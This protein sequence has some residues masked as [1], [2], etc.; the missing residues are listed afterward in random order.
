MISTFLG[1]FMILT[2]YLSNCLYTVLKYGVSSK[3]NMMQSRRAF[4]E[5]LIG[6]QE[7]ILKHLFPST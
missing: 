5:G 3:F 1:D 2:T 6:S 4:D 7:T